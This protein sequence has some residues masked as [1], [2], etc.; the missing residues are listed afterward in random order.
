MGKNSKN[1]DTALLELKS[2]CR[3]SIEKARVDVIIAEYSYKKNVANARMNNN[4]LYSILHLTRCL[5]SSLRLFLELYSILRGQ[6]SMGDYLKGL[7]NHTEASINKLPENLRVRFQSKIVDQRNRYMHSAGQ[8]PNR[9][10]VGDMENDVCSCL[11]S[12]L[13][14]STVK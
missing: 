3:S 7:T 9:R 10:E 12:V 1:V 13:A 8:F 4:E 5:D 11:Q 14:L 2:L 6:H